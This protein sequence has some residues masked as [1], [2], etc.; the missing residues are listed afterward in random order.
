MTFEPGAKDARTSKTAVVF[1]QFKTLKLSFAILA[2]RLEAPTFG[3]GEM[4]IVY[5]SDGSSRHYPIFST[6]FL[7]YLQFSTRSGPCLNNP[8]PIR[9]MRSL[10]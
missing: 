5:I 3:R 4:I 1:L 8:P 7:K 2:P 6:I 10:P 9:K